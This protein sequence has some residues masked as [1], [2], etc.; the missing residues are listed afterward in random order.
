M[1]IQLKLKFRRKLFV[2][3]NR[4]KKLPNPQL[5]VEYF[6]SLK[7]IMKDLY[8]KVAGFADLFSKRRFT[9]I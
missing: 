4:G 1:C 2:I 7:E 5:I 3:V 6:L 9:K 8:I